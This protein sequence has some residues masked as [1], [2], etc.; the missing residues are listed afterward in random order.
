MLDS[1]YCSIEMASLEFLVPYGLVS[2]CY[3]L[4]FI[5]FSFITVYA[6]LIA[7]LRQWAAAALLLQVAV[8]RVSARVTCISYTNMPL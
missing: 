8:H 5:W 4:M 6:M 3:L 7:Y 2:I 1:A